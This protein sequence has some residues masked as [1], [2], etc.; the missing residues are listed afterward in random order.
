MSHALYSTCLLWQGTR[1]GIAKLHGRLALLS[2][3]PEMPGL[4]VAAID[5][6]PEIGLRQVM[7]CGHA[8]RDMTDEEARWADGALASLTA[9]A[10]S[11]C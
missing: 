3:A 4:R 10:T 1:G 5:Y 9:A 11:S 8:W 6:I 2:Q 7:P